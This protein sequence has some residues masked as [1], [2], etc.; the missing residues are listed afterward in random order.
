MVRAV[1]APLPHE[2]VAIGRK[3]GKPSAKEGA[4]DGNPFDHHAPEEEFRPQEDQLA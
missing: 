2:L 1:R 4:A 3:A